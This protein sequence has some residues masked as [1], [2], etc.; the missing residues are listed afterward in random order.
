MK[1]KSE[2]TDL[3]ECKEKLD[4][5]LTEYNCYIEYDPLELNEVMLVDADTDRIEL[6]TDRDK[7]K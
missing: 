7:D 4:S 3:Q 2:L 1:K 5:L 6:L